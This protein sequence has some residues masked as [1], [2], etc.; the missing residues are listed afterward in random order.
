M[1]DYVIFSLRIPEDL[2]EKL[3][4]QAEKEKRSINN[5]ILIMI[6]KYLN[7]QKRDD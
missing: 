2:H 3:K 1:K 5:M 7:E 4:K 6:E